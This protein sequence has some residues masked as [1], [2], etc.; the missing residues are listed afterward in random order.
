MT[1]SQTAAQMQSS[2][3]FHCQPVIV[4]SERRDVYIKD[5]GVNIINNTVN[6]EGHPPWKNC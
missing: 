5:K 4:D 2:G 3:A 1:L 6:F